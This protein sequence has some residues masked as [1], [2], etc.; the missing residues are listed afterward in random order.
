MSKLKARIVAVLEELWAKEPLRVISG[1]VTG[2]VALLAALHVAVATG[3]V[4]VIVELVLPLLFG[5][6]ARTQVS[7]KAR[8]HK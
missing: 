5:E 8:P 4:E 6:L 3:E 1:A 7:P 2:V